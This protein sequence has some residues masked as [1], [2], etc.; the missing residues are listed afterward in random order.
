MRKKAALLVD[1][2]LSL[3]IDNAVFQCRPPERVEERPKK[4]RSTVDLFVRKLLQHDLS[5]DTVD[6]ILVT[7]RKFDW[8]NDTDPLLPAPDPTLGSNDLSGI[9]PG[10]DELGQLPEMTTVEEMLIARCIPSFS[11]FR[12][13]GG[14]LGYRGNVLTLHQDLTD[15]ATMLPRSVAS[16]RDN[17]PR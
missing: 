5:K 16:L 11:V 12:I 4:I 3:M 13:K 1:T 10:Y 17:V 7:L 8:K 9:P 14:A 6:R 2:R 15:F